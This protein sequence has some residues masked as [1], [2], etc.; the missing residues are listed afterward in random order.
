MSLSQLLHVQKGICDSTL[1]VR[2]YTFIRQ[3]IIQHLLWTWH[4]AHLV[5]DG[6]L[7]RCE[8]VT[9]R[10]IN[11]YIK[12]N[13]K[14]CHGNLWAVHSETSLLLR[15]PIEGVDLPTTLVA[16]DLIEAE[17]PKL[18]PS[19]VLVADPQKL[20][21]FFLSFHNY[22]LILLNLLLYVEFGH[23]SVS[24]WTNISSCPWVALSVWLAKIA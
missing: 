9:S 17:R 23:S 1:K 8:N 16:H 14:A 3:I 21:F 13:G 12:G 11:I 22:I 18:L 7:W 24:F 19:Y 5:N 15:A 6:G 2:H 20:S 4:C 10:A